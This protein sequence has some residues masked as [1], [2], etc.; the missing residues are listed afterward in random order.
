VA[1]R[2]YFYDS[3]DGDRPYSASDFARAFGIAFE[4]GILKKD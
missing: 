1:I 3:V 4:N 2:S